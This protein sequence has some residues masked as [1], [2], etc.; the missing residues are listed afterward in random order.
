TIGLP[1]KFFYYLIIF[2]LGLTIAVSL[3]V[4]GALLVDAFVL[5]PAM[6]AFIISKTLKQL[7]LFSSLFGLISGLLGLYLSFLFDI[8][9]SS[10]IIIITSLIIGVSIFLRRNSFKPS[11]SPS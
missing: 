1:E 9:T 2:I 4:I 3:R 6:G 10:T 11:G 5:L 7:F 8:P